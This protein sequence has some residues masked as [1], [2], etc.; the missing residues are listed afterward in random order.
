M[1]K[2]MLL[3]GLVVLTLVVFT[4]CDDLFSPFSPSPKDNNNDDNGGTGRAT[5]SIKIGAKGLGGSAVATAAD[6]PERAEIIGLTIDFDQFFVHKTSDGENSGWN[7]LEVDAGTIDLFEEGNL[8]SI[9]NNA[10]IPSGEYNKLRF[11]VVGA[12]ISTDDGETHEAQMTS[13][14]VDVNLHFTVG[15]GGS[16]DVILEIDVNKSVTVGG[17]PNPFYKLRP[18]IHVRNLNVDDG[19]DDDDDDDDDDA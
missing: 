4:A 17:G 1:T 10:G 19:D 9:I 16:V 15:S 8:E 11:Y 2:K 18:V 3:V 13:G 5:M 7:D 14:K 6:R 12:T